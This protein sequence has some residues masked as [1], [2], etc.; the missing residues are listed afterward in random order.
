MP[1]ESS[2]W[3]EQEGR[4][5]LLPVLHHKQEF[6]RA[7]RDAVL[8]LSPDFV[9]V[10]LPEGLEEIYKTAVNRLPS[11]SYITKG[12][13]DGGE[14]AALWKIE[15]TDPFCEA[16]RSALELEIPIRF[17][18]TFTPDYP[19]GW[20][21]LPDPYSL[22]SL[23][24]ESYFKTCQEALGVR[25]GDPREAWTKSENK[26]WPGNSTL[27]RVMGEFSLSVGSNIFNHSKNC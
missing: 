27:W 25:N 14:G 2:Y 13:L 15:P 11:L 20:D 6:A 1:V 22:H 8:S 17:V 23:G 3:V 5:S 10:E 7:V 12:S 24:L 21:R 9:A 18:D 16:V 4:I 26:E 19:V